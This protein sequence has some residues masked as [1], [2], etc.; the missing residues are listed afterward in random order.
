M[1]KCRLSGF[2]DNW[3]NTELGNQKV[4]V[5][6]KGN[7][8][9]KTKVSANGCNK[10]I[11][12]GE[13]F[14]KYTEIIRSVVSKTDYNEGVRSKCGD[15]LIPGSTTTTGI[16]LA[17]ASVVL[18]DDVLIGGDINII[19]PN[20]DNIDSGFLAY[21]ITN[22]KQQEIA[23]RAK[24]ITVHHLHGRDLLDLPLH[25]PPTKAE[26][27]AIANILADMDAEIDA[28]TAKLNKAKQIK[29]GMMS[30]LLTGRIRLAAA[31]SIEKRPIL[32]VVKSVAKGHNQQFDDA[33][34]IGGIVNS[35]YDPKYALGRVKV[36]KLLYLY[37]RHQDESTAEFHKKA[38]G[39]YADQVRYK[40]GEPIA[41][42]SGYI[43]ISRQSGKKGSMF[44]VGKNIDKA[45]AYINSWGVANNLKW[46]IDNFR[47][48][49]TDK[50]ELL[51]TVDMAICDLKKSGSP[52]TVKSIKNLIATNKEWKAKLNK[53]I[54]A[55]KNIA[56][57]ICELQTLLPMGEIT[58]GKS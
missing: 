43:S 20:L 15:I 35:F 36:Q 27:T 12:Y 6:L 31:E 23:V 28:L 3:V 33:V 53:L 17:R 21:Y 49:S 41:L 32:E 54:F 46:L 37:R 42:H 44:G 50:L 34:I 1:G 7:G 24:G 19:R 8:L 51:A 56:D 48:K 9:S 18:F 22:A 40:G 11:L 16:D 2:N 26:Q 55:D 45:L 25:I 4:S 57:A 13:L 5:V 29:Q 10:C 52:V 38:A 47:Y 39:P 58:N 30:E 14:T